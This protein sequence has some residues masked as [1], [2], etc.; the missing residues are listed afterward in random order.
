[1]KKFLFSLMLLAIA[2]SLQA[3]TKFFVKPSATGN[4]STWAT[5]GDFQ[6]MINGASAGDS[7]FVAGGTYQPAS[8]Q[9]F[10]MKDGVKIYGGFAGKETSLSQRNLAAGN[11]SILKGN[12]N[13]V[14]SNSGLSSA[15]VLDGFTITGGDASDNGGGMYNSASSPTLTNLIFVGNRAQSLV[16]VG[17]GMYNSASSPT[18]TNVLFVDNTAYGSTISFGG[19]MANGNSSPTLTNVTFVNNISA[20]GMGGG[21]GGLFNIDNSSPTLTNCVF[22]GNQNVPY[23]GNL[24]DGIG[25]DGSGSFTIN[26]SYT[27]AAQSGTGNITGTVDP[28]VNSSN[29]AGADGIYGTIDDGLHLKTGS[30]AI[31]AGDPL[32]NTASYSVQAGNTDLAGGSRIINNRIDMGA[33]EFRPAAQWFVKPSAT[34]NGSSWATAGDFQTIINGAAAGDSVFVAGG[35]Y[36]PATYTSYSMKE[37]VKIYGGFAG[38]ENSLSQRSFAA[39]NSSI[40]KG[41]NALVIDN[42]SNNLTTAAI[43]N[44]FTITNGDA[45]QGDGGGMYNVSSS[46]TLTNIN[47]VGNNAYR[48]GGMFN[49]NS[50]PIL[51]NVTLV[52]NSARLGGGIYNES[53]TSPIQLTNVTFVNNS[54]PSGNGGSDPGIGGA[55]LTANSSNFKLTNCIFWGNWAN[56]M[57]PDIA[58]G[59]NN[60]ASTIN[61]SYTQSNQS[62]FGTGNITSSND[63][64]VNSGN[65]AG[66]DGMYGTA[67]DGLHL[68]TGSTAIDAG[69]PLTNTTSYSVQAGSTD[70][71]GD[72]RIYNSRIDMG[73]YEYTGIP[74]PVTLITF[75][76]ILQ[77]SVADLKWQ[78]AE[79]ANF[80]HFE[81]EKTT[82]VTSSTW[83][84]QGSITAKGNNSNYAFSIPQS[85]PIAYYRLKMVDNDGRSKYSNVVMLSQSG[86]GIAPVLYP[87]PAKNSIYVNT[88]DAG[89]MRIYDVSGRL[90]KTAELQAGINKIDISNLRAGNFYGIV[91]GVT[92][93]FIKE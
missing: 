12:G 86:N 31:D 4:G 82:A 93:K 54:A 42:S 28:F 40:L 11:S 45:G 13:R 6:T 91:N 2:A 76:G 38:T 77:N 21:G 17:G 80:N 51:T 20:N 44:G 65:P 90:V 30:T 27:Q 41:H 89:Q 32:T 55:M 79:E 24:D 78:S 19:G 66:A 18:L 60:T 84:S 74:L 16:G 7:V 15:A 73:A 83:Q 62:A 47:L 71:V 53:L 87:N 10:S 92:L 25:N 26:Y 8:G 46:P 1:M 23:D 61:Y 3:Q 36:Q 70:I 22:W 33:Y 56:S 64:F 35:T 29:P 34:G 81:V 9:S 39:G 52:N 14:V 72:V 50:T 48:G 69:D 49:S 63:P 67:D 37:G 43:L 88:A 58:N 57:Y 68:K 5:A 85:E 75:K 59:G